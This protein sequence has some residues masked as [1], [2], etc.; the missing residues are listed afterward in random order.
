MSVTYCIVLEVADKWSLMSYKA[1]KIKKYY[2]RYY[3]MT[4]GLDRWTDIAKNATTYSDEAT[5]H[6]YASS[7]ND[8]FSDRGE[9]I[10]V[11][12]Y[13]EE[14]AKQKEELER[15]KGKFQILIFSGEFGSF[16]MDYV[17]ANDLPDLIQK[18]KDENLSPI[19]RYEWDKVDSSGYIAGDFKDADNL[20]EEDW[21][22]LTAQIKFELHML[23]PKYTY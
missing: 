7:L 19:A 18:V 2:P 3:V 5:A 6:S 12:N 21:N 15:R 17:F 20:D 11:K 23:I 10:V 8:R 4:Q 1:K 14:C 13:D 22:W 9:R 16:G